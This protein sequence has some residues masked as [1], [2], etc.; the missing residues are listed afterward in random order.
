MGKRKTVLHE[1]LAVEPD[2]KGQTNKV[3]AETER[4]FKNPGDYLQGEVVV[5]ESLLEDEPQHDGSEKLLV[6]TVPERT[7]YTLEAISKEAKVSASKAATNAVA[8]ADVILP[9]DVTLTGVPAEVLMKYIDKLKQVR[10]VLNAQP[11]LDN[12]VKW[13]PA[14]GRDNVHVAPTK[15]KIGT[16]K[17]QDFEVVVA[18]TEHHRAEIRD[19]SKDIPARRTT[20]TISSGAI[21]TTEKMAQLKKCDQALQAL[22]KALERANSTEVVEANDFNLILEMIQS[23]G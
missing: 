9:G 17:V 7:A 3:I 10:G 2:V 4:V 13:T 20:T 18:A 19:V 8:T 12:R 1:I 5:I 14:E 11:T 16:R 22:K 6:T 21:T 15:S 23:A